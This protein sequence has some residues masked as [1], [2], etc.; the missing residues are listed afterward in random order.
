MAKYPRPEAANVQ[1]QENLNEAKSSYNKAIE[2]YN[3]QR[4]LFKQALDLAMKTAAQKESELSI[5]LAMQEIFKKSED[6]KEKNEQTAIKFFERFIKEVFVPN[7]YES[8]K[9]P[10]NN[11]IFEQKTID[12]MK[13]CTKKIN[14]IEKTEEEKIENAKNQIKK[15]MHKTISNDKQ[16]RNLINTF[17]TKFLSHGKRFGQKVRTSGYNQELISQ[18]SDYASGYT[19]NLLNH[20]L[21]YGKYIDVTDLTWNKNW[22]SAQNNNQIGVS[23]SYKYGAMGYIGEIAVWDSIFKTFEN[24]KNGLG[25]QVIDVIPSGYKNTDVD[26]VIKINLPKYRRIKKTGYGKE[27]SS[28]K[29]AELQNAIKEGFKIQSKQW[30]IQNFMDPNKGVDPTWKSKSSL[31]IKDDESMHA[32]LAKA[33]GQKNNVLKHSWT[34]AVCY[35]AKDMKNITDNSIMWNTGRQLIWTSDLLQGMVTGNR[36]AMFP[37]VYRAY[38][39]NTKENNRN[40]SIYWKNEY[41]LNKNNARIG[42][43]KF[44]H[45][46]PRTSKSNKKSQDNGN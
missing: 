10:G 43:K 44:M 27:I 2:D 24:F 39:N 21:I 11:S 37:W 19:A 32:K 15:T 46:A 5:D 25:N 23:N 33:Y 41:N 14:K 7:I 1:I 26:T 36:Y 42:W 45:V 28:K 16:I 31:D 29:Y 9:N 8:A 38:D 34:V 30:D 20:C 35:V 18:L 3:K 13:K 40:R 12:A 4:N 22:E 6:N 17:V